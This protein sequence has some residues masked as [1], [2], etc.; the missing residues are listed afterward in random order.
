[1]A[2]DFKTHALGIEQ[3]RAY[4][5]ALDLDFKDAT[6]R[7]FLASGDT[8]AGALAALRHTLAEEIQGD[9]LAYRLAHWFAASEEDF[10]GPPLDRRA[11]KSAPLTRRKRRAAG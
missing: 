1:M 11:L 7:R 4:A 6:L 2:I 9:F 8:A 5:K 3:L 10:R